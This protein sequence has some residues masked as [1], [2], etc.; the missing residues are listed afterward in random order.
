MLPE[1]IIKILKDHGISKIVDMEEE[2]YYWH[3]KANMPLDDFI[4]NCY[5]IGCSEIIIG[6]YKNEELRT[7]SIFHEIGHTRLKYEKCIETYDR[8]DYAWDIGFS[9]AKKY[10]Y[11]FSQDT[12]EWA[13]NK[14]ETYKQG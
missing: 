10:G 11:K 12:Y 9:L 4:D 5:I 2:P 13:Y 7:A 1:K 3:N 14:L 8:E 6:F